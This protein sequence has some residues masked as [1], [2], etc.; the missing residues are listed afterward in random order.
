MKQRKYIF[1]LVELMVVITIIAILATMLL[2]ALS[3]AREKA[4]AAEC[5]NNLKQIGHAFH[6]YVNDYNDNLPLGKTFGYVVEYWNWYNSKAA[7][8]ASDTAKAHASDNSAVHGKG[9]LQPYLKTVE[10]TNTYYGIVSETYRDSLS[11]P[12]QMP[13]S[14]VTI[15][16]Y[17]Y[18]YIIADSGISSIAPY[19]VTKQIIR[20]LSIF[21]KPAETC[22]IADGI[23]TIASYISPDSQTD[24]YPVGYRHGSGSS[25]F[26]S[27]ANVIYIDGHLERNKFGTI[28]DAYNPGWTAA[29]T[30]SYFWSPFAK[31]PSTIK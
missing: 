1:T 29:L 31:D 7:E 3:K 9:R 10:G 21:R 17:G 19:P 13:V 15:Y 25:I 18:N 14:G 26:K 30:Q 20:K 11:C 6:F 5:G 12:S 8:N 28:P 2:P 16:T 22:L 24:N 27:S 4:R 23:S